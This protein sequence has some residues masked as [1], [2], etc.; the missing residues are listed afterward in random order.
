M[1]R[2]SCSMGCCERDN[3]A[4]EKREWQSWAA[5]YE[6][7]PEVED[8]ACPKGGPDCGCQHYYSGEPDEL[9]LGRDQ[10]FRTDSHHEC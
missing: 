4:A 7:A 10:T 1:M 9:D 3:R 6:D 8:R 5:E 2:W